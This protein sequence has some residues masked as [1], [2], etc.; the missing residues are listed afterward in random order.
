MKI[1]ITTLISTLFF[2]SSTVSAESSLQLGEGVNLIA[3]NGKEVNSEGLFNRQN[4][5]TLADGDVQLLV[6]Y[7]AEVKKG[8][9]TELETSHPNILTFNAQQ[10]KLTLSAPRIRS[11]S[12]LENFNKQKNWLLVQADKQPVDFKAAQL[13]VSGFMLS[14]DYENELRKFNQSG[15][16]A[17]INVNTEKLTP[18]VNVDAS[19]TEQ[20]VIYRMLKQWYDLASPATQKRFLESVK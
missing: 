19:T 10:Q 5:F 7:T 17:A 9:E 8:N 1:I 13:P 11:A 6:S 2:L 14:V 16:D 3:V 12:N 18:Q 20:E 4:Q 15:N